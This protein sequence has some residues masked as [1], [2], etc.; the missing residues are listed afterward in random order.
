MSNRVWIISELFYPE[1]TSTGYFLTEIAKGV[2]DRVD[3]QVLCGQSS[4]S[5]RGM[6]APTLER[7]NGITIRRLKATHFDKDR[8][9][10]RAV[11][12]LTFTLACLFRLLVSLRSGDQIL[13][14]TNPP[15]LVPL[16]AIVACLRKARAILLVHDVY[17]EILAATGMASERSLHYRLLD[18]VMRAAYRSYAK[19]IVLGRDMQALLAQKTGKPLADIPI[20]PNWADR[21]EILP[22]LRAVNPFSKA[23]GIIQDV[24]IQ[25][26]GNIGRTHD[27]ESI[28][29]VAKATCD[30]PEILY[31]FIGF[32]GKVSYL[33]KRLAGGDYPNV[34]FLP[35]QPREML[36]PM[37]ASATA[38]VISFADRMTGLSVPSRMYNVMAA[39]TPIIAMAGPDSELA[40]TVSDDQSGW[41]I[42][43]GDVVGLEHCIRSLRTAE[44]KAEALTRGDAARAAAS[45]KYRFEDA[46]AL[47]TELL[48]GLKTDG[49]YNRN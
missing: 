5:E 32:G 6:T 34:R 11:N 37:L 1:Q 41:L 7:W 35:R 26:S 23:H 2:A 40:M 25:F 12:L 24:V 46:V 22:L 30:D 17:P 20:I 28:L 43:Q 14:V 18:R 3:V 27:I 31:M 21:D 36:G 10:L 48:S 19:I 15:S 16:V 49:E 39:G 13:L 8:L 33:A 4:Y 9:V 29:Q 38:I 42:A 45:T 47:Y 44:G